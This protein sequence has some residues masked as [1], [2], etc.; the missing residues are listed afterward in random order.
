MHLQKQHQRPE[1][2]TDGAGFGRLPVVQVARQIW[3][4]CPQFLILTSD[5]FSNSAP[6]IFSKLSEE[7]SSAI[8]SP[9]A[10]PTLALNV[11]AA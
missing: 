6:G 5:R 7:S 10:A 11:S 1:H 3:S 8:L 9:I 2:S 4:P